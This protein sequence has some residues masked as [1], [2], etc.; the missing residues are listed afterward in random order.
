[1]RRRILL[2]RQHHRPRSTNLRAHGRP[3]SDLHPRATARHTRL[4]GR[5]RPR[6]RRILHRETS[7][8][9]EP[10]EEAGR[11]RRAVRRSPASQLLA[12][13]RMARSRTRNGPDGR[14][15]SLSKGTRTEPTLRQAQGPNGWAG[16][17]RLGERT[18]T[19]R[20]DTTDSDPGP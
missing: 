19:D 3:R 1:M 9:V 8:G 17:D 2:H 20:S 4:V 7:S 11:D 15:L 14:S 10:G 12:D 13:H 5:V 6:G 18:G 16:K